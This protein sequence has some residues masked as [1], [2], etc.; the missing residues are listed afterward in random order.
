MY[1]QTAIVTHWIN[2]IVDETADCQMLIG[3]VDSGIAIFDLLHTTAALLVGENDSDLFG[4][5]VRLAEHLMADLRPFRHGRH[6]KPNAEAHLLS[7]VAGSSI[8]LPNVHGELVLG[9]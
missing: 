4:D 1:A 5:M 9:T 8:T 6:R 7:A 2:E 3:Q